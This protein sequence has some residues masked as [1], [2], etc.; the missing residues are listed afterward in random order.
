MITPKF[1]WNPGSGV[2]DFTPA[3]PPVGKTPYAPLEAVRHDSVTSSG[4]KQ[5]VTE[6]IDTFVVLPFE[7]VPESDM[8]SWNS[9][10][11]YALTGREFTYYP[12]STIPGTFAEYVL[13]DMAWTPKKVSWKNY[14]FTMKMRK[15]VGT[16]LHF[17]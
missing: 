12:D 7:N 16:G 11:S 8:A 5:S 6:R 4:I 3:I 1:A 2:V 13:E 14:G 17:S 10:F 15:G 9:F